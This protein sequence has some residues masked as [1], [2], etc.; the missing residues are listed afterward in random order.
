MHVQARKAPEVTPGV[1]ALDQALFA[2]VVEKLA[3]GMDIDAITAHANREYY[4]GALN[5]MSNP[6]IAADGTVVDPDRK[7]PYALS[8]IAAVCALPAAVEAV[9]AI[10]AERR[11][12]AR[13]EQLG[14]AREVKALKALVAAAEAER[15][16]SPLLFDQVV[17]LVEIVEQLAERVDRLGTGGFKHELVR[18]LPEMPKESGELKY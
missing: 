16:K 8:E 18:V 1:W 4:Y 3:S 17:A 5:G 15:A 12:E 7:R 9:K 6:R 14:R 11:H 13:V 10:T 2:F